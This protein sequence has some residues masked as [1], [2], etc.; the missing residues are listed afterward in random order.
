MLELLGEFLY[1]CIFSCGCCSLRGLL[2]VFDRSRP[3]RAKWKGTRGLIVL[4]VQLLEVE[5][6]ASCR[7]RIGSCMDAS[8]RSLKIRHTQNYR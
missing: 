7:T 2:G 8:V 3:L 4:Y 5:K 6:K 1:L